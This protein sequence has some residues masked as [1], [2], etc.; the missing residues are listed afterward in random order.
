MSAGPLS[1]RHVAVVGGGLAGLASALEAADRGARVTLLERQNRLGGLTWSFERNGIWMDNGQHVYLSC[2]QAYLSFLDRIGASADVEPARPLD[3]PVVAPGPSGPVVGRLRRR[4]LPVPL[5]L[6]GSLL[7]YPHLSLAGR[8]GLGRALG[9]LARLDLDDP[10]LDR[11]TFGE[12]LARKGQSPEAVTAV[13]DLITVPTVNLPAAEASLAVA[14]MVFK[15]GVLG[16][17][18]AVDMGWSRVPLGRLHGE[19]AEA[20]LRRAGVEVVKGARVERISES[21]EGGWVVDTPGGPLWADAVVVALPHEEAAA[22]VPPG[23]GVEPSQWSG[24]GSSAVVDVHLVF[25]R[26]VTHWDVMAGHGSDIQWVF[27]RTAASGLDRLHPGRQYLAVSLSAADRLLGSR[28]ESLAAATVEALGRLLPRVGGARL[29]DSMVTK[30]RRA[31]FR[32]APGTATLRP[33]AATRMAGLALAGAWTA[34]GWPATMEGAV[35]SG[36][37]AVQALTSAPSS[38]SSITAPRTQEVA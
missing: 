30:E 13:W 36:T 9:G 15:T 10:A 1:G 12:W 27:D 7:R 38:H 3:V 16:G 37:A 21:S 24:L 11:I 23:S 2:C 17:R 6:A 8:L 4:D 28:P 34:T 5:H 26:P 20:A 32:A 14:A 19:R 31:T 35:L 29:L 18:D 25:D 33:P 22:V